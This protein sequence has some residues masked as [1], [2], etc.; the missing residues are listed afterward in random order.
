LVYYGA[1]TVTL[2]L[3]REISQAKTAHPKNSYI[4]D[5]KGNSIDF[6]LAELTRLFP[7]PSN[8]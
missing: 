2:C 3:C 5:L 1:H 6:Q 7:S 8:Q 4:Q